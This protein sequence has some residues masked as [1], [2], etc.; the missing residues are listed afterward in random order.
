M[1][2]VAKVRPSERAQFL[3]KTYMHLAGAIGAFILVEFLLFQTGIAEALTQFIVASQLNWLIILGAFI[4]LGWLSRG[5]AAKAGEVGVQYAGLGI[6]VIAQALFFA[7]LV[8]FRSD[9]YRFHCNS[10]SSYS[11]PP[12]VFGVNRYC[13]YD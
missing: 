10:N 2:A 9:Y 11:D 8:F 4:L 6:Y 12:N 3:Q 7:P 5:F 13:L 1:I